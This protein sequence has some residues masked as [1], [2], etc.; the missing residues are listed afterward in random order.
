MKFAMGLFRVV[1]SLS[2]IT[3]W[4]Y[5]KRP[6]FYYNFYTYAQW[7]VLVCTLYVVSYSIPSYVHATSDL[8]KVVRLGTWQYP[9][10]PMELL[11]PKNIFIII[12]TYFEFEFIYLITVILWTYFTWDNS[13][14]FF[15][16]TR[17]YPAQARELTFH[18][19]G[20]NS[21]C[22]YIAIVHCIEISFSNL[23]CSYGQNSLHFAKIV[24][25]INFMG[26]Y[27][28]LVIGHT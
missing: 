15:I 9:R 19:N 24:T 7:S 8:S 12:R 13:W 11:I 28:K 14:V 6:L 27:L 2:L 18:V 1:H 26:C 17:R 3:T 23:F 20:I 21:L 10:P 25:I 5:S 4:T 22:G 16:H